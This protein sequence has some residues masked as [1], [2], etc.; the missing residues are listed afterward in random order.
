MLEQLADVATV[1]GHSLSEHWAFG[2][3]GGASVEGDHAAAGVEQGVGGEGPGAARR[4]VPVDQHYGMPG[5]LVGVA[6]AHAVVRGESR[7]GPTEPVP[8][9]TR[10]LLTAAEAGSRRRSS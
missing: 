5:A 7:H 9:S 6:E 1:S 3:T 2:L 10:P 4:G 8:G